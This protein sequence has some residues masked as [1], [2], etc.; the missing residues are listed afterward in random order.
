MGLSS[1]LR[2]PRRTAQHSAGHPVARFLR[3][4][5]VGLAECGSHAIVD[6]A[7]G[8]RYTSEEALAETLMRSFEPGMLII[9]DR[10]F[11]GFELWRKARDTGADL[12][13]RVDANLSLPV[14][15][16]LPDGSYISIVFRPGLRSHHRADLIDTVRAGGIAHPAQADVVRV[17]E[18]EIPDREG[19]GKHGIIRLIT[20]ILDYQDTPAVE[21]AAAYHERWEYEGLIDDDQNPPARAGPG[22]AI[23]ITRHGGTGSMGLV[24]HSLLHPPSHVS[25]GR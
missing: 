7:L 20:S 10:N 15:R 5:V 1:T 2:I 22:V 13:W 23:E 8:G 3:R 18:Y 17:V 12:L 6:A 19:D 16:P 24:A 21:L 25:G 4:G 9:A 14:V 11:Y